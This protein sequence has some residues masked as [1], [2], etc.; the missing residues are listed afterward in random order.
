VTSKVNPFKKGDKVIVRSGEA[1]GTLREGVEE[2]V[3]P[4][5]GVYTVL[6]ADRRS[7]C[8]RAALSGFSGWWHADRFV[9]AP[10]ET[11]PIAPDVESGVYAR[12]RHSVEMLG[13]STVST[14]PLAIEA[15][16]TSLRTDLNSGD[17]VRTREAAE[18]LGLREEEWDVRSSD[19]RSHVVTGWRTAW[20]LPES[21][22]LPTGRQAESAR[23][24]A[25]A[26]EL[27]W[28]RFHSR[29]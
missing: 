26:S 1:V 24:R 7:G 3:W 17:P 20:L 16:I 9:L 12:A 6:D 15:T 29:A 14:A 10:D 21:L 5:S 22:A 13:R 19:D 8:I 2:E 11:A 25:P 27:E 18:A 28:S 23:A 4:T